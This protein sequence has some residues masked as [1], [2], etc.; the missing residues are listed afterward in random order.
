MPE[1]PM[2][3]LFLES[4]AHMSVQWRIDIR[5]RQNDFKPC[6]ACSF[7]V[8]RATKDVDLLFYFYLGCL[9]DLL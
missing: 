7:S 1:V 4:S 5:A 9:S 8:S 6:R 3:R 2:P